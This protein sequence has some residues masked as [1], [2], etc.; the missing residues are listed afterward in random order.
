M[1]LI[2]QQV[3]RGIILRDAHNFFFLQGDE[4]G[5]VLWKDESGRQY[6]EGIISFTGDICGT[7]VLPTISTSVADNYDFIV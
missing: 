1:R 7:G 6:L 3:V 4:G 2:A 5:P